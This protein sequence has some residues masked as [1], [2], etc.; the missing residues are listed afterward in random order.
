MPKS[1]ETHAAYQRREE[2]LTYYVKLLSSMTLSFYCQHKKLY[3][4]LDYEDFSTK[5]I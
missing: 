1:T 2:T 5:P 3:L 4:S